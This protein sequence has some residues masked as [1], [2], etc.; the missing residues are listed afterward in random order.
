MGSR[1]VFDCGAR[2]RTC[3]V[4]EECRNRDDGPRLNMIHISTSHFSLVVGSDGM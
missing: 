4:V 3:V 1:A 2:A